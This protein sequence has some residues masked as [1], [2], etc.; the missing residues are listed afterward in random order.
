M[1]HKLAL[2]LFAML[3][4]A[5]HAPGKDVGI[6]EPVWLDGSWSYQPLARTTLK[7]DGSIVDDKSN[8]PPSGKMVIPANWHLNGL[9][10]FNGR[11]R[12]ERDFDFGTVTS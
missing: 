12:F 7:A 5:T 4:A 10:N 11:V 2:F 6:R 9:P 8:L 3:L 1:R